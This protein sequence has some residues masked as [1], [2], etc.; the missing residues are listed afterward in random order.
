MTPVGRPCPPSLPENRVARWS[1]P[2]FLRATLAAFDRA[3]ALA[4]GRPER[5]YDLTGAAVRVRYA[6][7]ALASRFDRALGPFVAPAVEAPAVVVPALTI[8]CWDRA[9]TGVAPP[10]AP[11]S[12]EDRL[13]RNRIRG[14]DADGIRA[15]YDAHH[16]VLHLYDPDTRHA[17]CFA[18]EVAR[19]PPWIERAPFRAVLGWWASDRGLAVV[20]ASAVGSHQGCVLIT[21]PSGSGKS[22]TALACV[23]AGLGIVG[24]DVTM[25][26]LA[27]EPT[28]FA[29]TAT[30]K[31]EA[32]TPVHL[33]GA[34]EKAVRVVGGQTM[35]ALGDALVTRSPVRA[36]IAAELGSD[37][38]TSVQRATPGQ[39][40]R[41]LAGHSMVELLSGDRGALVA[42]RELARR[43]PAWSVTLGHDLDGVVETV[44]TVLEGEP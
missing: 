30:A 43:V 36:L 2:D 31:L 32:G 6:G 3:C 39:C 21:G 17:V 20:H 42:L 38:R 41:A 14:F 8:S 25:V 44:R 29:T 12:A 19:I 40:F 27:P 18:Q 23:A 24:D 7:S 10:P 37:A 13:P 16:G 15:T 34:D 11:W 1:A 9:S 26:A 22:T 4:G 35:L 5:V 28:A 33:A